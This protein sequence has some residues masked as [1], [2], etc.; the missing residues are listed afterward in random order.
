MTRLDRILRGWPE[1][2]ECIGV[3]KTKALTYRGEMK[4]A[5]VISYL[6]RG[7]GPHRRT[8][9]VLSKESLLLTWWQT[10]NQTR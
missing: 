5:G 3:S 10:R 1:I 9:G 8:R 4:S 7:M 2:A 6:Y